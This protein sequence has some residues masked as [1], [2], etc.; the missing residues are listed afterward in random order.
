MEESS[1]ARGEG[2]VEIAT[3]AYRNS[4][5]PDGQALRRADTGCALA[6]ASSNCFAIA[7]NDKAECT[8]AEACG[9]RS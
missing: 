5:L 3:P 7:R 1:P 9:Y 6:T 8:Q 2:I 4:C